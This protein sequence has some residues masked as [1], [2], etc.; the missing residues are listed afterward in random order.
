MEG[1]Y[2]FGA[3]QDSTRIY[4]CHSTKDGYKIYDAQPKNP[5]RHLYSFDEELNRRLYGEPEMVSSL[6][7]EVDL[8]RFYKKAYAIKDK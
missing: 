4:M 1:K 2:G 8:G 7:L 6:N 5:Y 3:N